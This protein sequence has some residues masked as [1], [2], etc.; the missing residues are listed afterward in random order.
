MLPP[1]VNQILLHNENIEIN[2]DISHKFELNH[3]QVM[4]LMAMHRAVY[5][6]EIPLTSIVTEIQSVLGVDPQ[7]AKDIARE[8]L[9]RRY[10]PLEFYLGPVQPLIT[11][12]GGDAAAALEEAKR[13][14]PEAYGLP[15]HQKPT[16]DEEV[17]DADVPP[18]LQAFDRR[19]RTP[20][21][22]EEI[23]LRLTGLAADVETR[24]SSQTLP[25][26]D[27]ERIMEQ[28]DQ[29]G[30]VINT[31]DL[32]QFEIQAARR[33]LRRILQRLDEPQP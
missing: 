10:L 32:N 25:V 23:L 14:W 4:N 18:L 26:A 16:V 22:R 3:A 30:Y 17:Q 2:I 5:A 7:R 21:G 28:L 33:R 11:Q 9:S 27:G 20:H 8:V 31:Q 1:L 12:L 24:I 19:V 6:R 29:L 15:P 13:I